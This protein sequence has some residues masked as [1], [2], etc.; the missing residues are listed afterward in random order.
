MLTVGSPMP[1]ALLR[2]QHGADVFLGPPGD[3]IGDAPPLTGPLA[4]VFFPAAFTSVCTSELRAVRDSGLASDEKYGP[5]VVAISCDSFLTLRAFADAEK[6]DFPLLSDFWPHGEVSQRYDAFDA[7][8]GTSTR[9][10]YVVDGA[11]VI[12]WA[13]ENGLRDE[14]DI[15][16][17]R[18]VFTEL[19][20]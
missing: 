1:S 10:T 9:T 8:L 14:R 17:I 2:D 7:E 19:V 16:Q 4:V 18:T 15:T 12:R 6:I 20:S 13:G 5:S 11:G 3:G